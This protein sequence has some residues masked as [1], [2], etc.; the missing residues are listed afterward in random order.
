[1]QEGDV[2]VAVERKTGRVARTVRKA[3]KHDKFR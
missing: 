1:M 3:E 2:D